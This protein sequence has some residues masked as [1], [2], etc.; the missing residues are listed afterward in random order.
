MECAKIIV[1]PKGRSACLKS[2]LPVIWAI[3]KCFPEI[4]AMCTL[5]TQYMLTLAKVF[6]RSIVFPPSIRC[7]DQ[8]FEFCPGT[9]HDFLPVCYN[10]RTSCHLGCGIQFGKRPCLLFYCDKCESPLGR[11]GKSSLQLW[12]LMVHLHFTPAHLF[13]RHTKPIVASS[14][15]KWEKLVH[16]LTLHYWSLFWYVGDALFL[17]MRKCKV[18]M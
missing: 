13:P 8:V 4:G 3:V 7:F 18:Y 5:R 10:T 12:N 11:P 6:I 2:K 16:S 14:S 1:W 17:S 9:S 15:T